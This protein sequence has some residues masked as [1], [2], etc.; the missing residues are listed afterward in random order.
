MSECIK[1]TLA[2]SAKDNKDRLDDD[3]DGEKLRLSQRK[4]KENTSSFQSPSIDKRMEIVSST[5][6]QYSSCVWAASLRNLYHTTSRGHNFSSQPAKVVRSVCRTQAGSER[7]APHQQRIAD[8]RSFLTASE[9]A[10]VP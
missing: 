1:K 6:K 3:D 5:Q 10:I 8:R 2:D 4:R 9:S 7:I